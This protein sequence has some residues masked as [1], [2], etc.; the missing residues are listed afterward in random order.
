[1]FDLGGLGLLPFSPRDDASII[2]SLEKSDVVINM[3]G[4]HYETKHL[5]PT[6]RSDGKLS[7][8]N[9]D[10]TEV[11]ETIPRRIARL[12]KEAGVKSF[13]HVSALSASH[14]SKS[15]WSRSKALGEEAVREEFPGAIIVK[16]ATVF[17]AEDRFLNMIGEVNERLPAFPLINNGETLTQP[18]YAVDV[19]K[20]LFQIV[21]NCEEFKGQTF[22]LAG[23]A[24]YSYK[25]IVEFVSDVSGVKKPMFD[26]PESIAR[27]AGRFLDETISPLLTEDQ[28]EQMKEDCVL[29]EGTKMKTL[30]DLGIEPSSMDKYAFDFLH[31]FRPG[32]HFTM[33]QGYH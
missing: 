11:H 3:I 22:Q 8:V 2:E 7:R 19:G 28:I 23:P 12:A 1:M 30:V 29:K 31:R 21:N 18:V 32:G 6:R 24:E 27:F 26:A 4:K 5:V 20:A 16:P 25:E 14:D 9:Y 17:G 10:F 33:V 15:A 13:V